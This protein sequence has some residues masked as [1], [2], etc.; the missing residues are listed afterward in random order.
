VVSKCSG[1]NGLLRL[2]VGNG[3]ATPG[4]PGP[5]AIAGAG[6]VSALYGALKCLAQTDMRRRWPTAPWPYGPADAGHLRASPLRLQGAMA[7]IL[8]TA[9]ITRCC[10]FWWAMIETRNRHHRNRGPLR[11]AQPCRGCPFT[12]GLVFLLALMASAGVPGQA[13]FVA[14][15]VIY[16]GRFTLYPIP[17]LGCL[18]ASGLKLRFNAVAAVHPRGFFGGPFGRL[19]QRLGDYSRPAAGAGNRPWL[20]ML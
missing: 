9:L 5:A 15:M 11:T 19:E 8:P 16:Q 20:S 3:W 14:E 1:P 2:A 12:S 7:Q 4:P 17:T 6:M 18:L 10:L 13:G